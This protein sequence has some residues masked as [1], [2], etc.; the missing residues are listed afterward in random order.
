MLISHAVSKQFGGYFLLYLCCVGFDS[1]NTHLLQPF[2]IAS[3]LKARISETLSGTLS[4]DCSLLLGFLTTCK[5]RVLY[6]VF[7]TCFSLTHVELPV[8]RTLVCAIV[9]R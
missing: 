6:H 4:F 1:R 8:I 2:V 9:N 5:S 7:V 3:H